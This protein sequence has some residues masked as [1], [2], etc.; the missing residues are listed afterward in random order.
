M[1]THSTML[2]KFNFATMVILLVD[3]TVGV[4]NGVED[5][6]HFVVGHIWRAGR[7]L[8]GPGLRTEVPVQTVNP[9]GASL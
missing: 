9:T 6:L 8:R 4:A 1:L 2:M 7:H 5:V 3:H